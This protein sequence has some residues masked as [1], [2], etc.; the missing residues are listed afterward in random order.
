VNVPSKH[1]KES[2]RLYEALCTV[3]PE[4]QRTT[5]RTGR[6]SSKD[7]GAEAIAALSQSLRPALMSQTSRPPLIGQNTAKQLEAAGAAVAAM[8]DRARAAI[9]GSQLSETTRGRLSQTLTGADHEGEV[10]PLGEA[11]AGL[12]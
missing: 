12:P 4:E 11:A 1:F 3:I 5:V 10:S 6:R 8:T 9:S 7:A 2:Q